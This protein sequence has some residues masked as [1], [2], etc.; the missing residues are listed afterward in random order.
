MTDYPPS[1]IHPVLCTGVY[2]NGLPHLQSASL[3]LTKYK[4]V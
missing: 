2:S 4:G 1:G 3:S